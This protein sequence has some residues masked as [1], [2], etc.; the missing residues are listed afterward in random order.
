MGRPYQHELQ[1]LTHTYR[2]ARGLELG[3]IRPVFEPIS[4]KPL[5]VIGSGGSLSAAHLAAI[6]HERSFGHIARPVTPL[7]FR[8]AAPHLSSAYCAL[9]LSAGGRN[10]DV[11]SALK[12]CI[13][14]E[15]SRVAVL[16]GAA[17]TPLAR[18]ADGHEFVRVAEFV[19]PFGK[20]GFLAVNSLL[21]FAVLLCR[22]YDPDRG[23][24]SPAKP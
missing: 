1:G 9:I 3:A 11:L 23:G 12:T 6:L 10:P 7:E 2:W 18:M 21:A 8:G 14:F 19:A 4:G 17:K 24:G 13:G 22:L 20:D 16:C 5:T 15:T